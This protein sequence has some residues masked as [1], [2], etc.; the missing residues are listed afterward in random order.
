MPNSIFRHEGVTACV[1][2]RGEAVSGIVRERAGGDGYTVEYPLADR[3]VEVTRHAGRF[4]R[5]ADG[6]D[7]HA[8]LAALPGVTRRD[9]VHDGEHALEWITPDEVVLD[10]GRQRWVN[11][12]HFARMQ[13]GVPT[14]TPA[15]LLDWTAPPEG[16]DPAQV[17]YANAQLRF[18]GKQDAAHAYWRVVPG[19]REP[20]LR[21]GCV[22][23]T[24]GGRVGFTRA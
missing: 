1:N 18:C 2:D 8:R 22:E 19:C 6:D 21:Q 15:D 5:P 20:R 23:V 14:G 4:E 3:V 24:Y 11:V 13:P 7:W 9:Y 17:C 10:G 16:V 12:E